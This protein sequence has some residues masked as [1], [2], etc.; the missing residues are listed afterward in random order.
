VLLMLADGCEAKARADLPKGEDELRAVVKKVV[1]FLRSEGQLD[2]AALTLR[3]LHLVTESFVNTL[4]NTY[5]PRIAYPE[6]RAGQ[7]SPTVPQNH[8]VEEPPI[9]K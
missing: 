1:D 4:R 8:P 7:S 9:V 6:L 5:H 2:E 3:D